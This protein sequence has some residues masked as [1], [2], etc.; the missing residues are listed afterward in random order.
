MKMNFQI[1]ARTI[2]Q[3]MR[4][5]PIIPE[6]VIDDAAQALPLAP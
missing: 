1:M 4:M 2:Y 6:I 5:A 3:V